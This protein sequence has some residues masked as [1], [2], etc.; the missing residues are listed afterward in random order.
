MRGRV[1][2]VTR[3]LVLAPT[4]RE[5]AAYEDFRR[6]LSVARGTDQSVS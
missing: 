5:L 2:T 3:T 4:G 6:D 1:M